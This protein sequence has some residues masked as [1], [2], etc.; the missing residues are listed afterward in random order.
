MDAGLAEFESS[1]ILLNKTNHRFLEKTKLFAGWNHRYRRPKIDCSSLFIVPATSAAQNRLLF[2]FFLL[3]PFT[4]LMKKT[5]AIKQY[6]IFRCLWM[7]YPHYF[8]TFFMLKK[9]LLIYYFWY[10]KLP[11]MVWEPGISLLFLFFC[12]HFTTELQQLLGP[13]SQHFIFFV[14]YKLAQ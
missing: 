5:R 12:Y 14:T 1:Q 10:K 2:I 4:V 6:I 7:K 9:T 11:R 3:R 8:F 13:Y